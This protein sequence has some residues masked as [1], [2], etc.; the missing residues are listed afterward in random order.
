MNAH[1]LL[2]TAA[3][4]FETAEF[5]LYGALAH[6]AARE[7]ASDDQRRQ[8]FE[9]LVGHHKQLEVWAQHNPV[10]F[11]NRAAIVGAEIA[12]IEGRVLEAQDLYEKAVRSAHTHGF[13]HNEAIANERAGCF[14][15]ARGFE[16][17]ATTYLRDARDCYLRWGADGKVRQLEQLYPHLRTDKPI[18]EPNTTIQTSVERLDLATVMKVSEALSGEIVLEKLIDTLMRTAIEHAGAERGVLIL[19]RGDEYRIEAEVTTSSDKVEVHLRQASVTAADLPESV[20]RYV[21]RT[22]ESVLLHDASGENPFSADDYIREHHARSVLCL[23]ILKQARLLGMLYLE[24]NL[25]IGAFTPARMAVLKLLASE[26][27]IS[28]ENARLYR[29]LA[30]REARIR[31]LVDANIIGI[32]FWDLEGRILEANNAFLLMVGYD[33]EDLASGR[34]RWTDLTPPEW[35]DRDDQSCVPELKATGRVQPYEKE[36]FR[37]DGGRVP[38]LIGAANFEGDAYQGVAFVLDL[39]ER[40]SAADAMREVQTELAHAN[41]LATMGQL[42]ASIAHEVNQPI[43]AARNNAHAALRFLAREP[44]ELA[45]VSEALECVVNDTYR[46]GDIIGRIR[47]QVRNVPPRKESVDLNDAIGNVIAL[48]RGEL[49]KNCVTVQTRLAQGLPPVRAD[50]VQLQQVMLNL[51]LNAIEAM[52][53]VDAEVRSMVISTES[54]P[55]QGVLVTVGDSGPGIAPEHRERVFESFY[56]TKSGGLGIGLSICR[57]IVDAHGGRLWADAHQPRGAAFRFTLPALL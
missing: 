46:A 5:H 22:K 27:A 19:P 9:A 38:V 24:N 23:P 34:V 33:R 20:F 26:A 49:S 48:V 21:L 44:P 31:R 12:R 54:S 8:H 43:G 6:A 35:R 2:W 40:K 1:R 36:F 56:T 30:E 57:S 3:A 50:R 37:K 52:A 55:P 11:E 16:K 53:G 32:F 18:S 7:F 41:R 14:Y 47:D 13:V 15:A 4:N 17:I 45:E 28:M 25:T 29:D 51:I 39:T 10:T 42:A